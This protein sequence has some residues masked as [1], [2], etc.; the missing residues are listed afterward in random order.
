MRSALFLVF[1]VLFGF[2][3]SR[4]RATDYD[5][6]VAMFRL[7]DLHLAFVIGLAIATAALGFWLL[8]R[9]GGLTPS[10]DPIEFRKKP[11]HAGAAL[12]GLVF[13]TGWALTGACPGTALAQ[14]G[15]GKLVALVTVA[16]IVLGTYVY[17]RVR[18][19]V[20]APTRPS[21]RPM[22]ATVR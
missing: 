14:V 21:A 9:A 10:G 6:I 1:G 8:R 22:S 19:S 12:G 18:S 16:G 3:L 15:E 11:W 2:V 20:S 5:T 17:G 13:G 4:A 7:T